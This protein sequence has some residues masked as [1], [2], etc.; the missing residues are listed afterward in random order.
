ML[1]IFDECT[2]GLISPIEIWIEEKNQNFIMDKST[3]KDVRI[4]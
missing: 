3:C 4:R 1:A 2:D